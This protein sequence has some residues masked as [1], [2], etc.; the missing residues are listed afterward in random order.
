MTM[1]N[2]LI[3]GAAKCGTTALY[4]TLQQHPQVYMSPIKEPRFFAFVDRPPSFRGPGSERY[5]RKNITEL[6]VY[7][8]LFDD[9]TTEKA[10]GE[11]S[12]VYLSC[13]W[14]ERTAENIRRHI[15][16]ARLIALLRQ[17]AERAYS[18]Y[19]HQRQIGSERIEDFR[20]ALMAAA[21]PDRAD[22]LSIRYTGDGFYY[23]NLKPYF[24]RFPREQIRIYLYEDWNEHPR[25]TL[26]DLCRFLQVE[27][28]FTP[29]LARRSNVT[30]WTRSQRLQRF[31]VHPHPL[32]RLSR[33]CVPAAAR[34]AVVDR[35]RAFNRTA[36]PPLDPQLRRELTAQY[37]DDMLR[38]QA[39]IGRDLSHWLGEWAS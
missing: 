30:I 14:P 35:L 39:L 18:S 20:Q 25:D 24:E 29:D 28:H 23:A 13:W 1:P 2:F 21:R 5:N 17:P 38:L 34:L 8:G 9:V 26:R 15:P 31:L 7:Q 4:E 27:E 10:I 6:T 22:W 33:L 36:P 16:H 12:P 32:K 37:R 3:I 11:A 19:A